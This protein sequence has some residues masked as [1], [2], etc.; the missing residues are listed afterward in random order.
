MLHTSSLTTLKLAFVFHTVGWVIDHLYISI[1]RHTLRVYHEI[2]KAQ[3]KDIRKRLM[4]LR[5]YASTK[6]KT[7]TQL[8]EDWVDRLPNI[9]VGNS[10]STNVAD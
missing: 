3:F 8:I 1:D 7:I 6:E 2:W 5:T 9:E 4:K 10:S